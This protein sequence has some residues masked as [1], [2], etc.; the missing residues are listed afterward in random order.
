MLKKHNGAGVLAG[1]LFVLLWQLWCNSGV[2]K[3]IYLCKDYLYLGVLSVL[4]LIKIGNEAN[5]LKKKYVI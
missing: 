3:I 5:L 1:L 2:A 4:L